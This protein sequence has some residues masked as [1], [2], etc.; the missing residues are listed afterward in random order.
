MSWW[1]A[2]LLGLLQGLTEFLPV[3]SSGHLVIGRHVLGLTVLEGDILFEVLVH[4]GTVLSIF[5]V[6]RRRIATLIAVGLRDVV[7]PSEWGRLYGDDEDFFLIVQILITMIP[8]GLVYILLGD[9]LE[10]LFSL[11]RLASGMLIVTG[12]LLVATLLVKDRSGDLNARKSF[13]TGMAQSLAFIPGIS[14]SGATICVAIYQNVEPEKAADFSFLMLLP[15]VV[16]A[17][18]LK[19]AGAADVLSGAAWIPMLLGTAVAF[20]SGVAA[21]RIVLNVVRRGRLA[22]FAAYCFVVGA[23]GLLLI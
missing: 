1:E 4:F 3:S 18:I 7:R 14:R 23:I 2:A 5:F 16:G 21:I 13:V 12:V 22:W 6:Y 8:T 10:A 11:P 9:R 19:V 17:T 15:V 20:A